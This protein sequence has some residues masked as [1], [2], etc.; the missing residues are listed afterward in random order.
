MF[1]VA[2]ATAITPVSPGPADPSIRDGSAQRRLDAARE[3]WAALGARSYSFRV[4]VSC[5]CPDTIRRPRTIV[6]RRGKPVGSIPTHLRRYATVP[7]LFTRV[8]DAIDGDVARLT[9]TYGAR[10]VPKTIYVDQSFQIA[11]EE[12]GVTVDRVSVPARR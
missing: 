6:V 3:R 12:Q 7:R 4:R 9:A 11:D 5:F 10:G 2:P 1:A 8:Q